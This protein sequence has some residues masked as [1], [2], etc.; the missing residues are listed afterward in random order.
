MEH[1]SNLKK[2]SK[3]SGKAEGKKAQELIERTESEYKR[4]VQ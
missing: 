2:V 3:I 4:S 1:R